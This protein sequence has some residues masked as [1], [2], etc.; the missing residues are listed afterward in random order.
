M[1]ATKETHSMFEDVFQNIRKAA[2]ANLKLQQ[3]AMQQWTGLWPGMPTSQPAWVD[4]VQKFQK[5]WTETVSE[6]VTKHR[7]VLDQQYQ[8]AV[9]SLDAAFKV[10]EASTPE[11]FRRRS[12][13]FCRKAVDCLKEITESQVKEFQDSAAKWTQLVTKAGA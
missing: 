5:Q 7:E 1:T 8:A 12:E 6:L 3:E 4:K 9:E 13:Q 2:E 10:S 11:E